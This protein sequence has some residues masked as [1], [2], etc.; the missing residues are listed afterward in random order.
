MKMVAGKVSTFKA[1]IDTLL[2]DALV[3]VAGLGHVE[4]SDGTSFLAT[5]A[6]GCLFQGNA[7]FLGDHLP[8]F[9]VLVSQ[10][11]STIKTINATWRRHFVYSP[12]ATPFIFNCS[13]SGK[14]SG[15]TRFNCGDD[16][17]YEWNHRENCHL[18]ILIPPVHSEGVR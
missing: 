10:I 5:A 9:A 15:K 12:S 18:C 14:R 7:C 13:T 3:D 2:R 11:Q 8:H 6:A 1:E 4:E 16:S 17:H